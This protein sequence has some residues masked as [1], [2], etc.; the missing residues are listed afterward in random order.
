[1]VFNGFVD[2]TFMYGVWESIKM[3]I[4]AVLL[5]LS[6]GIFVEMRSFV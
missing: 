1:M 6:D 5:I 3:C 2:M 4:I